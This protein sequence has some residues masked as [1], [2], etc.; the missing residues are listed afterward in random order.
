MDIYGGQGKAIFYY[1]GHGI[2]DEANK[3]ALL[4]PI[5]GIGSDPESAYSLHRLY[6]ELHQVRNR[7]RQ[8]KQERQ[9]YGSFRSRKERRQDG[10]H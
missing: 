9:K 7:Q 8:G 1:A 2:P 10:G 3:T 6:D 4:L 5:D